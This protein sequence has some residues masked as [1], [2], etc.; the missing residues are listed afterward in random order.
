MSPRVF[1]SCKAHHSCC[2]SS[3]EKLRFGR[4]RV[5]VWGI[6]KRAIRCAMAS[7]APGHELGTTWHGLTQPGVGTRCE[8]RARHESEADQGC[9]VTLHAGLQVPP[10]ASERLVLIS[11]YLRTSERIRELL[12]DRENLRID[13]RVVYGK[14]DLA[15][16]DELAAEQDR[17][18]DELLQEPAREVLRQRARRPDHLD[19]PLRAL[20][21][22]QQRDGHPR[23]AR[24]RAQALRCGAP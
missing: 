5:V 10:T 15:P 6:G 22:E 14:S 8:R 12:S 11:P 23:R 24:E 1:D 19:E 3:G 2:A 4:G 16:D 20:A 17:H 21:G 9:V 18:P 7:V 13:I